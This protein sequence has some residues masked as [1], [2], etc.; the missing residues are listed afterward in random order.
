[1][2]LA[3]KFCA[4]CGQSTSVPTIE[5]VLEAD[6]SATSGVRPSNLDDLDR[7]ESV[8]PRRTLMSVGLIV[9]VGIVAVAALVMPD[10]LAASPDENSAATVEPETVDPATDDLDGGNDADE[11]D[12][13]ASVS[14]P[15]SVAMAPLTA[16]TLVDA[17]LPSEVLVVVTPPNSITLIDLGTGERSTWDP[18]EPLIDEDPAALAGSVIVVGESR[19]WARPVAG[20]SVDGWVE[21]GL[22]DRVRFSTKADRVWL[23]RTNPKEQPHDAEF[24]WNEVDLHGQMHRT[25]FRD[26]EIYFP[27][28]ELVAGI[29][30]DLFRLTDASINAWRVFSPYGVLLATGHNDLIVK[31]CKIDR[32][33]DRFWYDTATGEK[34]RSV[35]DD[36]AEGIQTSYGAL[37]SLDGRFVY[38]RAGSGAGPDRIDHDA[39]HL[40][41]VATGDRMPNNCRWSAPLMW[42]ANSEAFACLGSG[43]V[44]L[45]ETTSR[46]ALG[47]LDLERTPSL[48]E[49]DDAVA[50]RF[51]FVPKGA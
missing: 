19:A 48:D 1:M 47:T 38:S 30:G 49:S 3:T 51:V 2:P 28:P 11:G 32:T 16:D 20:D 15:A 33:C 44:E 18:P 7:G 22:A 46:S 10:Q 31:E 25:M 12:D 37:L 43:P 40:R 24:L 21:L 14:T 23:R 6:P 50:H 36:L 5:L 29:G 4:E 39:V 26:R 9:L 13:A 17:D 42:T 45:Y 35:F 27:T 34:R 41:S 8:R